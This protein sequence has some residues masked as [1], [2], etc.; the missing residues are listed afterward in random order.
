MTPK[1]KAKEFY[2]KY[3]YTIEN[4]LDKKYSKNDEKFLIKQLAFIAIDGILSLFKYYE[5][6]WSLTINYWTEVKKEIEK[7]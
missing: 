5:S 4:T 7:L 2:L 6:D 1:E 3:H